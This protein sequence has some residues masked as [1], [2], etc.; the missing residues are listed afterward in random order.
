MRP[1]VIALAVAAAALQPAYARTPSPV[2]TI[3]PSRSIAQFTVTKLGYSDVV[4]RFTVMSGEVRWYE[5]EPES[6]SVHWRVSVASVVTDA[7]R[8]D[9]TLLDAEYF[10]AR[11]HPELIFES[12]RVQRSAAGSL[13]VTGNLTMRGRTRSITIAVRHAGPASA[14]VFETDFAVDRYD[15]GIAGGRVM[16]RLIGRT[17]RIH[18]RAFTREHT[19]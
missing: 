14:P 1:R 9:R 3:D 17:V 12:T 18:L 4:G 16:G 10:D 11:N 2:F 15:F 13:R 8:R 5:P 7:A 19:S 6:G